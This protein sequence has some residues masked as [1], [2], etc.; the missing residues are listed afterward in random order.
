M[1]PFGKKV[2]SVISCARVH[3]IIC[4]PRKLIGDVSPSQ[5]SRITN[6]W[7]KERKDDGDDG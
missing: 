5:Y 7:K 3:F 6:S 2:K 1:C 4:T